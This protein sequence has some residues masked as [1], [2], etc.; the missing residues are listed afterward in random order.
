[1]K[2]ALSFIK[3]LLWLL[4]I[5]MLLDIKLMNSFSKTEGTQLKITLSGNEYNFSVSLEDKE[6]YLIKVSRFSRQKIKLSGFEHD[7]GITSCND[8]FK[9]AS[10]NQII[11]LIGDVGVHSQNLELI[12]YKNEHFTPV[13]F[14]D[15]SDVESENVFSDLPLVNFKDDSIEIDNRNYDKDPLL[16]GVRSH[17]RFIDNRFIFDSSEDITYD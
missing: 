5:I 2:K 17:Y 14:V 11:C 12:S 16:K 3:Y 1:M 8:S 7:S 9:F 10:N 6:A 13:L 4:V 15:N